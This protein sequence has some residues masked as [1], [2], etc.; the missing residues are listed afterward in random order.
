MY[1]KPEILTQ[2]IDITKEYGKGGTQLSPSGILRSLYEE[3][4]KLHK[5]AGDL[6]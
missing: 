6:V 4:V 1:T 2:A 5:E 3:L